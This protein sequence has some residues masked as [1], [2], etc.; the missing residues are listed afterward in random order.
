MHFVA[1][2]ARLRFFRTCEAALERPC[3][4]DLAGAWA[5]A[6]GVASGGRGGKPGFWS[7]GKAP[8]LEGG[9]RPKGLKGPTCVWGCHSSGPGMRTAR[10]LAHSALLYGARQQQPKAK[11][12]IAIPTIKGGLPSITPTPSAS[13]A[14]TR[15][16]RTPSAR[17]ASRSGLTSMSRGTT[18]GVE[19]V[20]SASDRPGVKGEKRRPAR[21]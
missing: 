15:P 16:R 20:M 17:E 11:T 21:V 7:G 14:S 19:P 13:S 1:L 4:M 2:A 5:N 9:P 12:G 8:L 18:A 6:V 10:G 3:S